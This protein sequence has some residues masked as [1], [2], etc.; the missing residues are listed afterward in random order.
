MK[1]VIEAVVEHGMSVRS[2]A[3]L[4]NVPKS[5]LGDRVSG[6]VLPGATSGPSSYLTSEE[7]REVVTFLCR[8]TAIG[9]GRCRKEVIAIVERILSSRGVER[10]VTSGWWNRFSKRQP[11]LA[12]R[13]PSTLS[14]ARAGASDL[15]SINAYF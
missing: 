6:R 1:Q 14:Y 15:V 5:T 3:E 10:P 8:T 7:E 13:I 11:E 9:Y 12:L 2:A 4:Y